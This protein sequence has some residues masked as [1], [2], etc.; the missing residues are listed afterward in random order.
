MFTGTVRT[1]WRRTR[2]QPDGTWTFDIRLMRAEIKEPFRHLPQPVKV[3]GEWMAN[4]LVA[5]WKTI[6]WEGEVFFPLMFIQFLHFFNNKTNIYSSLTRPHC[7]CIISDSVDS[8]R[9]WLFQTSSQSWLGQVSIVVNFIA[10]AQLLMT[11]FGL[12][13]PIYLNTWTCPA[14]HRD[15]WC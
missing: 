11:R 12:I 14:E 7:K 15:I 4:W 5:V 6:S 10:A 3:S 1:W 2:L 8:K 9:P 13:L